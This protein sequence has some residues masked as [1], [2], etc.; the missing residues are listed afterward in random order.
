MKRSGRASRARLLSAAALA[1]AGLAGLLAFAMNGC[2][3]K[4]AVLGVEQVVNPVTGVSLSRDVQPIFTRSCAVGGCHDAASSA[5]PGL[6]LAPGDSYGSL[7]GV[8]SCETSTLLRVIPRASNLSYLVLKLLGTQAQFGNCQACSVTGGSTITNCG[9]QM[10][11][12]GSPLTDGEL[13]LISD[14]IDQGAANN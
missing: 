6:S 11:F 12:G 5:L 8:A 7:V 4:D 13:Q 9:T 10:P 1:G 3:N 14:W 2:S